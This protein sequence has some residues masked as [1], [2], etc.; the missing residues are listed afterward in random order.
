LTGERFLDP[1]S[2]QTLEVWY[3]REPANAPTS[4][5]GRDEQITARQVH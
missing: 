3:S 4:G 1:P 2:A 5:H